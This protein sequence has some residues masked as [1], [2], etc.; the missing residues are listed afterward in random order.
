[1]WEQGS[2][3]TISRGA[4]SSQVLSE[5]TVQ[6]TPVEYL[7]GK[8]PQQERGPGLPKVHRDAFLWVLGIVPMGGCQGYHGRGW[9]PEAACTWSQAG[10]Q[11]PSCWGSSCWALCH[12]DL[13]S[14][15]PASSG[16]LATQ[17]LPGHSWATWRLPPFIDFLFQD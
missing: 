4:L 12:V 6:A 13:R 17:T 7:T 14:V 8:K 3:F 11:T 10:G 2:C 5:V 16:R 9:Q 15:A 1:M